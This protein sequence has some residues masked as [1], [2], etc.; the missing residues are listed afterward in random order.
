MIRGRAVP[1]NR[2]PEGVQP[3]E[4]FDRVGP[5]P[6]P[7]ARAV[8]GNR[9]PPT[10]PPRRANALPS[11]HSKRS[12]LSSAQPGRQ[13]NRRTF[14]ARPGGSAEPCHSPFVGFRVWTMILI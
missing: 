6:S 10:R 9:P 2:M 7:R 13:R 11:T 3:Q 1:R 14:D 5:C 4:A 8:P 12:P